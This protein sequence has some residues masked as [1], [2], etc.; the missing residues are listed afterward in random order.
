M[1]VSNFSHAA[2]AIQRQFIIVAPGSAWGCR[3]GQPVTFLWSRFQGQSLGL[4]WL[5]FEW[6]DL[7][8]FAA[9]HK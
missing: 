5:K 7:Y 1:V 6:N 2:L 3:G 9:V 8:R 4:R